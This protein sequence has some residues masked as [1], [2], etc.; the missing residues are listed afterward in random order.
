MAVA[1]GIEVPITLGGVREVRQQIKQ[2]RG[3]LINATD[4]TEVARLSEN[5]GQLSDQLKD[6]NEKANVFASGSKFE[7]AGNALGLMRSQIASLDFEGAGESASLFANRI[8]A[9]NPAEFGTQI[10]GL[11]S[12]VGN[13]GKAFLSMGASLLMNPIFLI[14]VAIVA[15]IAAVG[16]LL[17]KLGILKPA[18]KAIGAVF[19]VIGDAINWVIDKIKEFLDWL[20]ISNFAEQ[21]AA[22]KAAEAAEKRADAWVKFSEERTRVIDQQIRMDK[23]DNKNT[24]ELE[25]KK[26]WL[27]R[28]TALERIKA[29]AARLKE[30]ITSGNIDAEEIKELTKQYE[31]QKKIIQQS[32]DDAAYIRKQDAKQRQDDEKKASDTSIKNAQDEAKKRADAYKKYKEDRIAV[33]REIQDLILQA[34]PEGEAKERAAIEQKYARQIEDVKKNEKYLKDERTKIINLLNQEQQA[35][36]KAI[37]DKKHQEEL[38]RKRQQQIELAKVE[39]DEKADL[40]QQIEAIENAQENATLSAKD[41]EINAVRDKY[42]TLIEEAKKYGLDTTAIEKQ[43]NDEIDK[44]KTDQAEKDKAA[45][46]K[47]NEDRLNAVKGGLSA[48]GDLAEAWAGKDKARQKK[49]FQ[50]NK[51]MNIATA[52]ID[53]YK[54]ATAAYASAGGNPI[55][56][57]IMAAIVVASGLANIAKIK[58]TQFEGG[59]NAAPTST[60]SSA[61]ATPTAMQPTF[62]FQGSGNNANSLNSQNDLSMITV[63]AVVSESEVTS[64]Q[65]QVSKYENSAKL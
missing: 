43:M 39:S 7:Q 12:V 60:A 48:I 23:L 29:L 49:A 13:L 17:N 4:P 55:L 24:T 34:M 50:I 41:R 6:A 47:L 62:N 59:G 54:G 15:I 11:I 31:E 64:T 20:E 19:E 16:A 63:K 61:T 42:F 33:E 51:A 9:I 1:G 14:A 5:I 2:L 8:R 44:I 18:L 21:E 3:E 57:G 26:Q 52:T 56:G 10:K 38:E 53:T 25:L 28:Q 36:L 45:Q 22:Q 35:E 58:A 37:D 32:K 46:K 65:N 30:K 27:I 40:M